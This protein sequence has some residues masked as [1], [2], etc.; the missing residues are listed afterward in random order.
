MNDFTRKI[1]PIILSLAI[2]LGI[3]IG[4]FYSKKSVSSEV[5]KDIILPKHKISQLIQLVDKQYVDTINIAELEEEIIPELIKRLDPHSAYIPAKDLED[6]NADL[7]GSFS[8]IGVQFNLQNDTIYIVDVI[9]G[10]PSEHAGLVAGDRIVEVNDTAFVGKEVTN[11]KVL[12]KLRGTRG[13]QVKLGVVR[14]GSPE[15]L[16][17]TITRGD[18]P[19][20]SVE[21]AYMISQNVGY[22]FVSKFG[23]N[24]YSE[25]LT[26]IARLKR[27]GAT[28]F[29]I[30]LR[31]N[32]GGYLDASANMINEFLLAGELIVYTEGKASPR[33]DIRANGAG[34]CKTAGV[35]VLID[36]FSGSASEIFAGAIQDNDRGVILGRRSFGKGL[37]QQQIPFLDGS[38]V[39]LTIARYHTPS[40]R[41]IQKPYTLG[42]IQEYEKDILS[43]YEHG[44]FYSP[45]SI[46]QADS[47]AFETL[48]KRTV[49][50]GGGIMPDIFVPSDTSDITPFFTR[51]FNKSIIY[52]FAL[53][54]SDNHR[55]ELKN[56]GENWQILQSFLQ[57]Q[58]LFEKLVAFA[59]KEKISATEKEKSISKKRI[60]R[61]IISYIIRNI[62]GDDGFYPAVNQYD[63]CV[64]QAQK[65]LEDKNH[66]NEI[67]NPKK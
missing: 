61:Q 20:K 13:S 14:R 19:V 53:N 56:V 11:E 51:L 49:F 17:F 32:S 65:V 4:N 31:G 16:H 33:S 48:N 54:Y 7:N 2:S 10:G 24:T 57:K 12:K 26:A 29:I 55:N 38:A 3:F 42:K 28:D 63:E 41:C 50:G 6:V 34:S 18:I 43:R 66:Y 40:G 62:L 60:E 67:L 36:E 30:D 47:L 58:N 45:D 5:V 15:L 59:E 27:A 22:I 44:E 37:V 1:F 35:A 23:A 52:K 46:R 8:G 21:S 39:R 9:R 64:L 25:F